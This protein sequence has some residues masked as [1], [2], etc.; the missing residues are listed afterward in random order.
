LIGY[1]SA[2][3]RQFSVFLVFFGEGTQIGGRIAQIALRN[4][5]GGCAPLKTSDVAYEEGFRAIARKNMKA[6]KPSHEIKNQFADQN[7]LLAIK[8]SSARESHYSDR[9]FFCNLFFDR[10]AC[11]FDDNF[12]TT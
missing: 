5:L 9:R 8:I 4:P 3:V 6:S 7:L 11:R 1:V 10:F 2:P 12:F